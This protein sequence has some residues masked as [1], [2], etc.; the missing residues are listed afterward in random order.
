MQTKI[1]R[2][3]II[4]RIGR[5]S[6]GTVYL[7]RDPTLDRLVAIKVLTASDAALNT[8]ADDGT[9][10]EARISSK[11]K[12]PNIVPIYDAGEY[13][14]GPYLIFEYV[15]GVPLAQTLKSRGAMSIEDA[16]P[17]ITAI[18]KA[19]STAHAADILHLDLSPRN[20]LIDADNAPRVM[21]FGLAQYVSMA[22]E[23]KEFASGTLRYMAPEHFQAEP[24]GPVP[25]PAAIRPAGSFGPDSPPGSICPVPEPTGASAPGYGRNGCRSR[26][27]GAGPRLRPRCW[28]RTLR[29]HRPGRPWRVRRRW[30]PIGRQSWH[31]L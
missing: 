5:G 14:A 19:L 21:D 4:R 20:I 29:P 1:G 9:P 26:M 25:P 3:E 24:L 27:P 16:V 31:G 23:P 15:E 11:L 17:M 30:R 2:Y 22:R 13:L 28:R 10:L 8:V 6:Q 18:L 7:G 12:H